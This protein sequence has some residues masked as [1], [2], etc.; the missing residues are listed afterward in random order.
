MSATPESQRPEHAA[1][2]TLAILHNLCGSCSYGRV[3]ADRRC[4]TDHEL[5]SRVVRVRKLRFA[6]AN[7][8]VNPVKRTLDEVNRGVHGQGSGGSK[9]RPANDNCQ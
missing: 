8:I 1:T 2:T 3:A 6:T 7:H 9:E 5:A 4:A